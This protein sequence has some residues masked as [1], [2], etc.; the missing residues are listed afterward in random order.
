MNAAA[1]AAVA[2]EAG[3][4]ETT[5]GLPGL[6]FAEAYAEGCAELSDLTGRLGA[7]IGRHADGLRRC[8]A[9][10]AQADADIAAEFEQL[11]AEAGA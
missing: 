7:S 9:T 1:I 11:A 5:W 8:A 6:C 10:Y 3:A 4:A 2:S